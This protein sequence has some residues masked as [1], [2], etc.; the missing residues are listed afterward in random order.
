MKNY[1]LFYNALNTM[2]KNDKQRINTI[3]VN[4]LES[5][6]L[7][8]LKLWYTDQGYYFD[9]KEG[10]KYDQYMLSYFYNLSRDGNRDELCLSIM[11]YSDKGQKF[12]GKANLDT[13][14]LS[15]E[16]F[17]AFRDA[18]KLYY[19][20]YK[21]D[22]V[23]SLEEYLESFAGDCLDKLDADYLEKLGW[24]RDKAEYLLEMFNAVDI[25]NNGYYLTWLNDI[26]N[27]YEDEEYFGIYNESFFNQ[28]I[29]H[30][31]CDYDFEYLNPGDYDEENGFY[32][33]E[34]G[35]YILELQ[36]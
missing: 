28:C 6:R 16:D 11:G 15:I 24:D 25:L 12:L 31:D 32:K 36:V 34:D 35:D 22:L 33:T 29:A 5:E 18:L 17:V 13:K 23:E 4:L 20:Q 19:N 3:L 30:E 1:E 7:I 27:C 9:A 21:K 10:D 2:Y 8:E 26:I 14:E